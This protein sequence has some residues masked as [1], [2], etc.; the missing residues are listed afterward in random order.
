MTR[1]NLLDL[2]PDLDRD[3][4]PNYYPFMIWLDICNGTYNIVDE[5]L[6]QIWALSETKEVNVKV[7]H[8]VTGAHELKTLVKHISCDCK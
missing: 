5:L 1:P 2:D 8:K 6:T 4:E 3:L 7:F